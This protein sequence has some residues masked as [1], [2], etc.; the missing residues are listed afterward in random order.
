MNAPVFAES[1]DFGSDLLAR[2][3]NDFNYGRIPGTAIDVCGPFLQAMIFHTVILGVTGTGKTV[4]AHDIIRHVVDSGVKTVCVDITAQYQSRLSD[5]SPHHL[6]LSEDLV[7][8]LGDKLFDAETGEYGAG[9]EKK[10]LRQYADKLRA[11]IKSRLEEFIFNVTDDRHLSLI[12]LQEISNTKAT[13]HITEMYLSTLFNMAKDK[14]R[15]LPPV[16]V[17]V[18][19]AHTVMPETSTMGLGDFE[20]KGLVAKIS[21]IALQGRKYGIGLLVIAQ[22]TATV[23]KS[24][25][26]QCNNIITFSCFDDTSLKFL[27]NSLGTEHIKLIPNLPRLQ[28]VVHGPAF[29]TDRPLIVAIPFDPKKDY[30]KVFSEK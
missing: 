11:D 23:S 1:L 25:L 22:R 2:R 5:L 20:S 6:S 17:V 9:K 30:D 3:K 15:S 26:T 24:V 12:T 19:E 8:E 14:E 18:E 29:R 13:L 16:L 7:K 4:L 27:S 10:I 28:A 21:Q